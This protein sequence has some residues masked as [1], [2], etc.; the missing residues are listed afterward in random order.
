MEG[1]SRTRL[2]LRALRSRNY[3]LF[4]AGQ[5][6]SLIGTWM[7]Q[8]AMSWLVYRMTGSAMLLGIV[9]FTSQIPSFLLAPVAGVLADRW[10]KRH[11]LL[12]TQALALIQAALLAI[13]VLTGVVQIWHIV[14]LSLFLGIV[15]AFDIPIRQS[16]VVQMVDSREDLSNAIALNSSMVHGARLIGPTIAGL[17]VASVGEGVCFAINSASYL[18][19]IAALAAM[20]V[21]P[22]PQHLQ[23]QHVL[24]ELHEGVLY[25]FGSKPI[26]NIIMLLALISL[27]GM[28]Y[29]VLI[30]VF[31]REVLHG[32]SHTYGFLMTATGS[33]ALV[34]AFYLASR[35]S[36][37]GLGMVIVRAAIFFGT[38]IAVFAIS[39]IFTLSMLSLV[40]AGFGAMTLVAS[41]NTILQTIVDEDKR[42]RVMS[43]FTMAFIGMAPFGSLIAGALAGRIGAKETVLIG[44]MSCLAG[45]IIFFRQLPLL[46]KIIR[47]IYIDRGIIQEKED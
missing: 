2:F 19:V 43:F 28:P 31:A 14:L 47:P 11:L 30:P 13:I 4:V 41:C 1:Q 33:G 46:R 26:R 35:R 34:G 38:G 17:L 10:E 8:V 21:A 40:V 22:R 20:R 23:R 5:G 44:G 3:R 32:S 39:N 6:I 24:H 37:I 16:F 27:M 45:G 12:A 9:G 7:Q 42:G 29:S 18:A 36:V 25:A 15:N